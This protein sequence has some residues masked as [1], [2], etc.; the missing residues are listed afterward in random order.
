MA[1]KTLTPSSD[2]Y[3]TNVGIHGG[4]TTA[5]DAFDD[6]VDST[7]IYVP[8]SFEDY[9]G[10]AIVN[11]DDITLDADEFIQAV[12]VV[13]RS[14]AIWKGANEGSSVPCALEITLKSPRPG[15]DFFYNPL[16]RISRM[17]LAYTDQTTGWVELVDGPKGPQA[18]TKE[19]L[20]QQQLVFFEGGS[21]HT[22]SYITRAR[23]EVLTNHRPSLT[24]TGP[25]TIVT[26]TTAPV[27]SWNYDDAD[28]DTQK[29]YRV[30]L[31]TREQF[32][33]P[34]FDPEKASGVIPL[35]EVYSPKWM[36]A[37][38]E[39]L[40]NG[41]TYKVYVW[42][43]DG[44]YWS[45]PASKQFTVS[46][47]APAIPVVSLIPENDPPRASISIAS[48]DNMLSSNASSAELGSDGFTVGTNCTLSRVANAA[49][50]V[51]GYVMRMTASGAGSMTMLVD[52]KAIQVSPGQF[53]NALCSV[54]SVG[55]TQRTVTLGYKFYAESGVLLG[56]VSGTAMNEMASGEWS[57]PYINDVIVPSEAAVATLTVTVAGAASGEQHEVDA[58]MVTAGGLNLVRNPQGLRDLDANGLGDRWLKVNT[59][60]GAD[61]VCGFTTDTPI[62]GNRSA[63][64]TVG[65][66]GGTKG[67]RQATT[68]ASPFA[69]IACW[70]RAS[71]DATVNI[72]ADPDILNVSQYL[73]A[74]VWTQV[75]VAGSADP[76][77]SDGRSWV[78]L[79]T[80]VENV[81]IEWTDWQLVPLNDDPT[82]TGYD[83]RYDPR[84][85]NWSRGGLVGRVTHDIERSIDGGHS[86]AKVRRIGEQATY[87]D[88][89]QGYY[90]VDY[91]IPQNN[92]IVQ[93]RARTIYTEADGRTSS[94]NF[95]FHV[96]IPTPVSANETS[97]LR[98]LSGPDLNMALDLKLPLSLSEPERQGVFKLLGRPG[99]VTL[100]GEL[101]GEEGTLVFPTRGD[102]YET[103]LGLRS[104]QE[105]LQLI[106]PTGETWYVDLD[107][108]KTS[109]ITDSL[110]E[111]TVDFRQTQQP[112]LP[113]GE[114]A[115]E[116]PEIIVPGTPPD[117]DPDPGPDPDPD[118][119]PDPDPDPNPDVAAPLD[120]SN[121]PPAAFA[122]SLRL[123]RAGHLK[124]GSTATTSQTT[125]WMQAYAGFKSGY[126]DSSG[127]VIR[128]DQG[129]DLVSEGQ[130]YALLFAVM[131]GDKATFD[132]VRAWSNANLK[133]SL[134]GSGKTTFLTMWAWHHNG[135][136]TVLD[137]NFATDAENDRWV[138]YKAAIGLG[139]DTDGTLL[140][141]TNALA[142]DLKNTILVD[143][144]YGI[145]V[146]DEYQMSV[147]G[148]GGHHTNGSG[149][150]AEINMSYFR[151][152]AYSMLKAH[153]G[154]AIWDKA[155]AGMYYIVGKATDN[156]STLATT[157]GLPPN[158]CYYDTGTHDVG[159]LANG[160]AGW[161]YSR[162]TQYT[163]D[164]FRLLYA[165]Y[166][167]AKFYG[168]SQ[169]LAWLQGAIKTYFT[170]QW[171]SQGH[172]VAEL[173]HDGS[174]ANNY[175]KSFF[176]GAARFA[177]VAGDSGNSTAAAMASTKLTSLLVDN[178]S[179][180]FYRSDTSGTSSAYYG[181]SW[182]L[183]YFAVEYGIYAKLLTDVVGAAIRIQ[184]A[185]DNAQMDIGFT[186][187]GELDVAAIGTF[188]SGTTGWIVKWYDQ[189]GNNRHVTA[190]F[191]NAYRIYAS[192][193]VE[194]LDGVPCARATDNT[195]GYQS[196][197]LPSSTGNGVTAFMVG[198]L[199]S[200]AT[201]SVSPR[202]VSL[203]GPT[204]SDVSD[205]N[206]IAMV[207][208]NGSSSPLQQFA[209]NRNNAF[210]ASQGATYGKLQQVVSKL[211][212]TKYTITV[213]GASNTGTATM[214]DL[215]VVKI[216]IGYTGSAYASAT[217]QRISEVIGFRI[218]TS[219]PTDAYLTANQ[220]EYF[221]TDTTAL[222][223]PVGTWVL[224][225][226]QDFSS[227]SNVNGADWGVYDNSPMT[228]VSGVVRGVWLK[229]SCL[230][231]GGKLK[232]RCA[233]FASPYTFT[234]GTKTYTV[235]RYGGCVYWKGPSGIAWAEGGRW[236]VDIK[237]PKN[238]YGYGLAV[239]SW[240]YDPA[241]WPTKGEPD[242]LEVYPS[243]TNKFG[244]ESNMHLGPTVGTDHKLKFPGSTT[245]SPAAMVSAGN[246]QTDW[247]VTHTL[248]CVWINN[249]YLEV[250][251]DGNLVGRTTDQGFVPHDPTSEPM[252]FTLQTE[253]LGTLDSAAVQGPVDFEFDNL[254]FYQLS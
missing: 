212:A 49:A 92:P 199:S 118:P 124:P 161:G 189:S 148:T 254:R 66:N 194:M 85:N 95:S 218:A 219:A 41:G 39:P 38:T 117:P 250:Y 228:A 179:Y 104:L 32:T 200:T 35:T 191:A 40:A 30:K 47:E 17:P 78:T 123:L 37:L 56:T 173:N 11:L 175:E 192:G 33:Q 167:H 42:V 10:Y 82:D 138:A 64:F 129:N 36:H 237:M 187:D 205:A 58:L 127:R 220:A 29:R 60:T 225:A 146:T 251:I 101:D 170:N 234:A 248:S 23:V 68:L 133:R 31:F 139:W 111:V 108:P 116:L 26:T 90:V 235:G 88:G 159:P 164:A 244:G 162:D 247:T 59:G 206:G 103:F 211:D 157:A 180:K 215:N 178:G 96:T 73:P 100:H 142:A 201:T 151:P 99:S 249:G 50:I 15:G 216:G 221:G 7:E 97:W 4:V 114:L 51:G 236:D 232:I 198:S 113:D 93:Y 210:R 61:P 154:D 62:F 134:S 240:P 109:V 182:M 183:W 196:G 71:R 53:L 79:T 190:P 89:I 8:N 171:A 2:N 75:S 227:I 188:C 24:I 166:I 83:W 144:V 44:N 55:G 245:H 149:V 153:T 81:T 141:E 242:W 98:A 209:I 226:S 160:T 150:V 54:R 67:V 1:I 253:V 34:G 86:W 122:Y 172:V 203:I 128:H 217:D 121:V 119:G 57:Q 143:G 243:N 13:H 135:S 105:T 106:L 230:V 204:N 112:A 181:D 102:E 163:Y 197:L 6:S 63:C 224:K 80:D 239:L 19:M 72:Q 14:R 43:Y 174:I 5:T 246:Y 25:E 222:P 208:R 3:L 22:R 28:G 132:L 76:Q 107:E 74:N 91:E 185:S 46:V 69:A 165:I 168:N 77:P 169:A 21:Q 140:T 241:Y 193:A 65:Q 152:H 52:D 213:D 252:R 238:S 184:R 130:A 115:P 120:N 214:A 94:S 137:W 223:D 156:A 186:S 48:Y 176:T 155:I 136:S 84:P 18:W 70:I 177:L 147:A 45:L 12:R 27:I 125:E 202:F 231:E 20:D 229:S 233:K 16:A 207:L 126:I 145:Q 158:W 195:R 110:R 131:A 87:D 9:S